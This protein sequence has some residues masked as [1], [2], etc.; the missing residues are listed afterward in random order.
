M[1]LSWNETY[2]AVQE[3]PPKS[4]CWTLLTSIWCLY[5]KAQSDWPG[6][7]SREGIS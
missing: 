3:I 6:L 2:Q 1:G 4:Q 5:S 7:S